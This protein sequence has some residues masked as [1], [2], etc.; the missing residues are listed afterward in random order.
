MA[1]G[2]CLPEKASYSGFRRHCKMDLWRL[3]RRM[4]LAGITRPDLSKSYLQQFKSQGYTQAVFV[5]N[6][7]AD[8]NCE[9][10]NNNIYTI[11]D[12]LKYDNPLYRTSH[13]NC[14]CK[15]VPYPPSKG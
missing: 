11:D 5:A 1:I 4:V 8:P 2:Y 15:F 6:V 13:P 12:L 14:R 10:L 7:L 3:D 9:V